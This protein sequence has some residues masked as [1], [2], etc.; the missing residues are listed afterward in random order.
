MIYYSDKKYGIYLEHE[1]KSNITK[2]N[3][4]IKKLNTRDTRLINLITYFFQLKCT[5]ENGLA[6]NIDKK[7]IGLLD[8]VENSN[9]IQYTIKYDTLE[10][11]LGITKN[12]ENKN[13]VNISIF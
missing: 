9:K 8:T 13:V 3:K 6:K 11:Y 4:I 7:A 5:N 10:I 12:V 2:L 1:S